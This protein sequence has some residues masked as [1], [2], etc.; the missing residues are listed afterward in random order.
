MTTSDLP[1]RD[2]GDDL[3]TP[4]A[5]L[6]SSPP[7][8][9]GSP[10][11]HRDRSPSR[12][13]QRALD[14]IDPPRSEPAGHPRAAVR[15]GEEAAV[16]DVVVAS[17]A[18]TRDAGGAPSEVAGGPPPSSPPAAA[19][20]RVRFDASCAP[21]RRS[22]SV[23]DAARAYDLLVAALAAPTSASSSPAP[24]ADADATSTSTSTTA[25]WAARAC[26]RTRAAPSS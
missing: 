15:G 24:P 11:R 17:T 16:D 19:E 6:S 1:R 2:V 9:R 23:G 21:P 20:K 3:G 4:T 22:L 5:L 18:A 25:R 8:T 26:G 14:L 7:P 12:L 13:L 10:A